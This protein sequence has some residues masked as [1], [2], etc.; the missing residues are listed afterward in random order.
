M[1]NSKKIII[2]VSSASLGLVIILAPFLRKDNSPKKVENRHLVNKSS[3]KKE[4]NHQILQKEKKSPVLWIIFI[5]IIFIAIIGIAYFLYRRH[6][7]HKYLSGTCTIEFEDEISKELR[8]YF[9]PRYSIIDLLAIQQFYSLDI[10]KKGIPQWLQPT[11][12]NLKT[13]ENQ[14]QDFSKNIVIFFNL[15]NGHLFRE[16]YED[17]NKTVYKSLTETAKIIFDEYQYNV[18]NNLPIDK[19]NVSYGNEEIEKISDELENEKDALTFFKKIVINEKITYWEDEK[20]QKFFF[21]E[22]YQTAY[23]LIKEYYQD[24]S[25][26]FKNNKNKYPELQSTW[27]NIENWLKNPT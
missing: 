10:Q 3:E 5:V 13:Y 16:L 20:N 2:I 27:E 15:L 22:H 21:F 9:C 18:G 6:L 1:I 23:H 14:L 11:Y 19:K 4:N 24:L 8:V 17:K 25:L 26:F 12:Q 7:Y